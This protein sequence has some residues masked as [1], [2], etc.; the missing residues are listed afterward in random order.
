MFS[1]EL[2]QALREE[3]ASDVGREVRERVCRTLSAALRDTGAVLWT[4]GW[5]IGSDRANHESPFKFGSDATVGLATIA[6]VA[7]ELSSG[8][9]LLLEQENMYSAAALL[10]QIV[11]TEYLAWAFSEDKDEA[12]NWMQSSSADRRRIWKPEHIRNRSAGRFRSVDYGRHCETGGHPTPVALSLLPDHENYHISL[13]WLE[14]AHHGVSA[15][16]Y[17]EDATR[18]LGYGD[19]IANILSVQQMQTAIA[20]WKMQDNLSRVKRQ[21]TAREREAD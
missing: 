3:C 20:D 1:D 2:L 11:E 9:V 6:Q 19:E 17:I 21:V 5:M 16:H 7:G 8:V 13:L 14:L 10:R 15:W 12:A 18:D 4:G